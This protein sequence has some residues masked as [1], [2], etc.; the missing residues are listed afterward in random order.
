[1]YVCIYLINKSFF[2]FKK[3][4]FSLTVKFYKHIPCYTWGVTFTLCYD[5][6]VLFLCYL[7]IDLTYCKV[8]FHH[9]KTHRHKVYLLKL[10]ECTIHTC[11]IDKHFTQQP[12]SNSFQ[13]LEGAVN[14]DK[15]RRHGKPAL[16]H[17]SP[18]AAHF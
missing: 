10:F 14:N 16:M 12:E 9:L 1:M 15:S 13:P 5:L 3:I 8:I 7:P 18:L 17:N 2:F 11:F 6:V 4:L